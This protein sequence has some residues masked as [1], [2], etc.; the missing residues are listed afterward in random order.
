MTMMMMMMLL[1]LLFLWMFVSSQ[2]ASSRAASVRHAVFWNRST[3]GFYRGEYHVDVC[4]NDYLDVFCPHYPARVPLE[5]TERYVLYMV[6]QEG[7]RACDHTAKGF[8]RWECDRPFSPGGP[9][10]F[11][12]KFQLFTPFSLGFEFRPGAHYYYLSPPA[13]P[14]GRNSCLK[15]RVFVQPSNSCVRTPGPHDHVFH[16]NDNSLEPR[17]DTNHETAEPSRGDVNLAECHPSAC[18]PV[19]VALLHLLTLVVT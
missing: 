5:Q 2:D 8:K 9:L 13:A 7:Y 15:M 16:V 3:A 10:R 18:L 14:G 11:S 1:V 17:D 12:E 19:L 4:I 6:N